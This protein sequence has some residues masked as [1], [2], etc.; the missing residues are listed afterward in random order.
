VAENYYCSIAPHNPL[1]PI[2]L[3]SCLQIDTCI[4]NFTAQEHPTTSEGY[5]LGK[6]FFKKPFEINDGYIEIPKGPGL[7]FDVDEEGIESMRYD[8][9][10][11][12]P[13]VYFEDD[14]SLGEW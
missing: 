4:P 2:A 5:D 6:I 9:S 1:G 13:V 14:N 10:W 7:G 12:G 11:T 8:G 3:A